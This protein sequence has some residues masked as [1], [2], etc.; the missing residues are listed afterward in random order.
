MLGAVRSAIWPDGLTLKIV[1]DGAMAAEVDA[2]QSDRMSWLGWQPPEAV[3][4][5]LVRAT[6]AF[7]LR[8][9]GPE[10]ANGTSPFKLLEAAAARVPTVVTRV[11][12]QADVAQE[13]G[14]SVLVQAGNADDIAAAVR[15][16]YGQPDVRQQLADTAASNVRRFAWEH[17]APTLGRVL[18]LLPDSSRAAPTSAG[19]TA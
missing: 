4:K 1:G 6:L 13:L 15:D 14:G 19:I 3:A 8:T 12:G 16:L 7:A 11:P 18:G 17:E 2:A 5:L 10:S 9:D